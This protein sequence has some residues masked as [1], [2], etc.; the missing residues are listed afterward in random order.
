[1]VGISCLAWL[2]QSIQNHFQPRRFTILVLVSHVAICGEL[3]TRAS[4]NLRHH[5]A[6]VIFILMTIFYTIGQRTII[7]SNFTCLIEYYEN[8]SRLSRCIFLSISISIIIADVLMTPAGL[9][10]FESKQIQLSFIFRQMST[11]LV[12]LVTV[13]FYAI[14]YWTRTFDDMPYETRTSLIISSFNSIV[15]AFF[16]LV[17][18]IPH[19]YV[20]INDDEEWFYFFQI[21]PMILILITCSILH[22]KRVSPTRKRLINENE[23][24]EK[25]TVNVF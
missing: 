6:K 22:P 4:S 21:L 3:I 16:L 9:L 18:S 1:M 11:A 2:I 12:C 23:S 14:W 5:N 25:E 10:S 7:I 24:E 17:M 8:R 20:I 15:I 13:L 19:Y